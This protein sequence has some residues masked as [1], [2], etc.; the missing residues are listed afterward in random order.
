MR[1][2]SAILLAPD[3]SAGGPRLHALH[4]DA[5]A[6]HLECDGDLLRVLSPRNI[7]AHLTSSQSFWRLMFNFPDLVQT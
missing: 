4:A 6:L 2:K 1:M 5:L 3:S 7:P